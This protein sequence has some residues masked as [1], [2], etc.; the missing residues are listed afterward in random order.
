[1]IYESKGQ[2]ETE[3][4]V[5]EVTHHTKLVMGV[6]TLVVHDV[7]TANS[8]LSED[9][10]DWYA[11]HRNGDV[12]YFGEETKKYDSQGNFTTKGS[13]QAG[14]DGAQPGI[15]MVGKP[16]VGVRYR[17]EYYKGHAE[18]EAEIIDT[19]AS[20]RVAYGSFKQVVKTKDYTVLEPNLIEHKYFARGLG[21]VLVEHVKGPPERVELVRVERA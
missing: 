11:Q 21:F 7:V 19:N 14:V 15:V 18:D 5:V 8:K 12:W 9:T 1:M 16:T 10:Y 4:T 17:Q 3:R 13:F 20:A 6:S 2:A